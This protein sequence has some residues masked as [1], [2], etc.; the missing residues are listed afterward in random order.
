MTS[1]N[2]LF[3]SAAPEQKLSILTNALR[4]RNEILRGSASVIRMGIE[5]DSTKPAEFL[6]GIN[7][8]S[9]AAEKIKELLDEIVGS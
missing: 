3:S 5:S 7:A 4:T 2:N 1:I 6:N 9:E 8:I